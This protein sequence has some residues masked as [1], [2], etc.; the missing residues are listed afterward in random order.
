MRHDLLR[1]FLL[2]LLLLGAAACQAGGPPADFHYRSQSAWLDAHPRSGEAGES[3][4]WRSPA[5]DLRLW[6]LP[7]GVRLHLHEH[8]EEWLTVV[9]GHGRLRVGP[10]GAGLVGEDELQAY[11]L[12]AGDCFLIPRGTA[13]ALDGSITIQVLFSPPQPE[14]GFDVVFPKS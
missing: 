1:S 4:T 3:E 13:H 5:A 9:D 7:D 11:P 6:S 12:E 2:P 14:D 10:A 8:R